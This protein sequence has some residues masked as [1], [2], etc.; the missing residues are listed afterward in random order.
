MAAGP[1]PTKAMH[2]ALKTQVAGLGGG[3]ALIQ[4]LEGFGNGT[5]PDAMAKAILLD[6]LHRTVNVKAIRISGSWTIDNFA[7]VTVRNGPGIGSQTVWDWPNEPTESLQAVQVELYGYPYTDLVLDREISVNNGGITI[8]FASSELIKCA[9]TYGSAGTGMSL[10]VRD[11]GGDVI[12]NSY[13]YVEI[14]GAT[15]PALPIVP[16]PT[17]N[18]PI[19]R[20]LNQIHQEIVWPL[21][22]APYVHILRNDVN[23][24]GLTEY[25][26]PFLT[27][28]PS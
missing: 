6:W 27:G 11:N 8:V 22:G 19:P 21:S 3:G 12:P 15:R 2:E 9:S 25:H 20:A 7:N 13:P 17:E 5:A 10:E 14:L 1:Y 4:S 16:A 28:L 18:A 24:G 26:I 23:D